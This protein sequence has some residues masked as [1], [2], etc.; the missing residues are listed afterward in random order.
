MKILHYFLGFPPYRSGG[1]TRY[2]FDLMQ[3]QV[4]MGE[5][6]CALWPGRMSL[7]SK[8]M[9][10]KFHKDI[11][12]IKNV[13]FI[14]P[15]PVPL[16][17]GIKNFQTYTRKCDGNVFKQF[18]ENLSPDVIHLH[19]LMG[20]P[21]EFIDVANSLGIRT[22]FTSH[23]YFGICPK[24]NLFK[25]GLCC[26]DDH[27]CHDCVKCNQSALSIRKIRLLQSPLYRGV[28]NLKLVRYFREK[29]RSAF[30]NDSRKVSLALDFS[31]DAAE[32]QKL[33]GYYVSMLSKIDCIHFNSTQT[34]SIYERFFTP[35]NSKVLSITHS[36][37]RDNRKA[38][39]ARQKSDK[40]RLTYLSQANPVKGFDVMQ[41][42]LDALWTEGVKNF[43]LNLF[44]F[45]PNPSPYMHFLGTRYNYE[46]LKEVFAKTD[47][48]LVPSVCYET[49]GFVVLEALSYGVPVIVSDHVGARDIVG[50][51]GMIVKAGSVKALKGKILELL[52]GMDRCEL[53]SC[54][55][56]E[57]VN[58]NQYL[59]MNSSLY[60]RDILAEGLNSGK[61]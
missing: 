3:G 44:C 27:Q 9:S 21:Q 29:H 57:F 18:L 15:L 40:L 5:D 11:H 14:N 33:R 42:A 34:K 1:M 54:F 24:V 28:K 37:I 47:Y 50:N 17:E 19:T 26:D 36:E 39:F 45:V 43:E 60:L 23:D 13:E 25:N 30:F 35:K 38:A 51:C 48:L 8:K 61:N 12:G 32:Y 4:E 10:F 2:A 6:V 16:D 56:K 59:E 53:H 7:F 55:M 22:V 20:L 52:N 49:F 58:W 46:M 31:L 41:K